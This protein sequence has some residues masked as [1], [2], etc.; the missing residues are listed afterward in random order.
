MELKSMKL[1]PPKPEAKSD[2]CCSTLYPQD[3]YPWGTRLH[4]QN[5]SLDAL[6]ITDL[7]ETETVVMITAKAKVIGVSSSATANDKKR[8]SVELQITDMALGAD[9]EKKKNEDVFYGGDKE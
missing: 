5:E 8:R 9:K 2:P 4:L 6:G 1:P 7:P 3:E